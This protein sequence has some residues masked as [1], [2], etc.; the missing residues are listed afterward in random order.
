MGDWLP[1]RLNM[2]SALFFF[3][4]LTALKTEENAFQSQTDLKLNPPPPLAS[5]PR[6]PKHH[7]FCLDTCK[8]LTNGPAPLLT[9]TY[10]NLHSL[11]R[12]LSL[13]PCT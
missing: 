3:P 4:L 2:S 10:F 13:H 7:D 8:R 11:T 5:L 9:P 6:G 1:S 12:V